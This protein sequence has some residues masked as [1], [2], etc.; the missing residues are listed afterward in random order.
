MTRPRHQAICRAS[1]IPGKI[2]CGPCHARIV[3]LAC[4]GTSVGVISWKVAMSSRAA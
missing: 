1:V 2:G 3:S 4:S